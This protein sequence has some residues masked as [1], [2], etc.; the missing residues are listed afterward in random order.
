MTTSATSAIAEDES[1]PPQPPRPLKILV[2]AATS[3][4]AECAEEGAPRLRIASLRRPTEPA[5]GQDQP[6]TAAGWPPGD[7]RLLPENCLNES[8]EVND[9][10]TVLK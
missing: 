2:P 1:P 9:S 10:V 4:N 7:H 3:T 6:I 8:N 5:G